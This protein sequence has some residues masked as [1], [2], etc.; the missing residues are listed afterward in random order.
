MVEENLTYFQRLQRIKLNQLPKEAVPKPKKYL[1]KVSIKKAA[2]NKA[3]KESGS[4]NEMDLFFLAMRK[5]CRGKCFFCQAST[6]YKN[7]ELWRIAIAHLLPKAKFKSIAVNENNWVELCWDC[8]TDFDTG[9][10]TWLLLRDSEEWFQ[11]KEKLLNVLPM[12]S[13]EER[14][15]KLFSKLEK[16]IYEK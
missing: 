13:P 12:V 9:Q 7:E 10:I 2:E 11:L 16:L 3:Q 8:H 6:T 14:K 15:H 1:N 5:K 4:D